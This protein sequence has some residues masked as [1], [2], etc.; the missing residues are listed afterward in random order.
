M[1]KG[2]IITR[3]EKNNRVTRDALIK[4]LNRKL[5]NEGE[6]LRA[7]RWWNTDMGDFYIVD[8]DSNGLKA[9]HVDLEGLGRELGVLGV[10]D[11]L[12]E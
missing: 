8:R 6:I 2:L 4:R 1:I 10:D 5:A 9:G 11:K 3:T 12:A 7:N